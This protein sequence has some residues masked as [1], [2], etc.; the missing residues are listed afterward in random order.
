MMWDEPGHGWS[1]MDQGSGWAMVAVVMLL[2]LVVLVPVVTLV[3]AQL[4][5]RPEDG[6]QR[7]E[8]ENLLRM[9]LAHGEITPEEFD[10]LE[11]T[12]SRR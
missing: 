8:P 2:V 10:R 7:S 12:L 5:R 3:V 1:M 9:R 6:P 4:L 11:S